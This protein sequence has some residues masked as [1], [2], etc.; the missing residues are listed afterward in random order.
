[1]HAFARPAPALAVAVAL[2]V[3]CATSNARIY[4]PDG[5]PLSAE[6]DGSD[7]SVLVLR[8]PRTAGWEEEP[9]RVPLGQYQ[10]SSI[11]HPGNVLATIGL[12]SAGLGAAET[13]WLVSAMRRPGAMDNGFGGIVGAITIGTMVAGLSMFAFN[14][15]VWGR[16]KAHARAFEQARPPDW[17]IPPPAGGDS[18]TLPP[19]Q[20]PLG[21]DDENPGATPRKGMHR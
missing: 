2:A 3:G 11:D 10:V 8:V 18:E 7:A 21:T 12:A 20:P 14:A 1:M 19:P 13:A 17:L 9:R 4:R 6:I 15:L 5:P 16:S